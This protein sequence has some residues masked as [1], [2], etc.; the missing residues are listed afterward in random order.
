MDEI[1][2]VFIQYSLKAAASDAPIRRA[3]PL[4]NKI[5]R[6]TIENLACGIRAGIHWR[7]LDFFVAKQTHC[8]RG[9][10]QNRC[11]E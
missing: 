9:P 3:A 11:P 1:F 6:S 10:R 8:A 7:L 5:R 2:S 4:V